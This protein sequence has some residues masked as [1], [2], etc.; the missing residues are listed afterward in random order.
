[1]I[2]VDA[3]ALATALGDDGN[4]GELARERLRAEDLAAPEIIDLEV[5]SVGPRSRMSAARCS[6]SLVSPTCR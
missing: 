5:T 1:V 3:S 4:D 6:L 2:V